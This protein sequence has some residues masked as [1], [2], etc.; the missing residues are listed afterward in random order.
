MAAWAAQGYEG[1]GGAHHRKDERQAV[2]SG[3]RRQAH[4]DFHLDACIAECLPREAERP[5]CTLDSDPESCQR[6][7]SIPSV[8]DQCCRKGECAE[9]K[10]FVEA[11]KRKGAPASRD[12]HPAVMLENK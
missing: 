1:Q 2:D 3:E 5:M 11:E 4:R 7:Q 10:R 12:A 9:V 6:G 8:D